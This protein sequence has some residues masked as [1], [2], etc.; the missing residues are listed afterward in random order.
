[1]V[2]FFEGQDAM[3]ETDATEMRDAAAVGE[4]DWRLRFDGENSYP[5]C[6]RCGNCCRTN[7]LAM[8]HEEVRRIRDYIAAHDVH[9]I[10]RQ[11]Q[12]CCLYGDDGNCMVWEA[13]A[14]VCR[15]HNCHVPRFEILRQNPSIHVPDDIPL[16]DLHECFINGREYDPRYERP[17]RG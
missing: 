4:G 12:A 3:G 9:P 8:T 10:D 6:K 13:R 7:V 1:M 17:T 15:L 16:V 11:R 14:Q 5:D 2:R